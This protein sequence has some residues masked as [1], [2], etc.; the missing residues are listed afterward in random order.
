MRKTLYKALDFL[1]YLVESIYPSV[2]REPV[3]E[4]PG[5]N[6]SKR[7]NEWNKLSLEKAL[8]NQEIYYYKKT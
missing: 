3:T 4:Q 7:T 1:D 6:I 5:C 8:E 2:Q